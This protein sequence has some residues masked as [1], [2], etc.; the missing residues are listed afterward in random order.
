[1][2]NLGDF[3]KGATVRIPFNSTNGSGASI[4]LATNGTLKAFKDGSTTE[5]TA[6]ITFSEDFD[7]GTGMHYALVDTSNA[8]Y[9][10]PGEYDV[11]VTGAIVDGQTIN[12]FLGRFSLGRNTQITPVIGTAT[13]GAAGSITLPA[14]ASATDDVYNGSVVTIVS[15]T[16]AGQS[17]RFISDYVGSTKVASV[18]PNW[19]TTPD[20]TSVVVVTAVA[21][22]PTTSVPDVNVKKLVGITLQ[23]VGTTADAFR[24]V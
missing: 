19:T 17:S 8:A 16:G 1:M 24:P 21:P 13:A 14:A 20:A 5:I 22:A 9:T 18:D 10:M 23:G 7:A 6:G 12:A 11:A 2:I 4:T 15:G 3:V